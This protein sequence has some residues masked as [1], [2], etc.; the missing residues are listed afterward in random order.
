MKTGKK[1]I[2][3]LLLILFSVVSAFAQQDLTKFGV[4][5][6]SRVYTAYFRSSSGVR[7]Y[8]NKKSEFQTEIDKRTEELKK[9]Q[10]KKIDYQNDG[11]EAASLKVEA[12]I[13]KKT[14]FLMEYTRAKNV[15]LESLKRKLETSD[16][17]YNKLYSVIERVAEQ[18][19]F[20]MIMSLQ[21]ANAVLWY[22]PSIDITDQF[23]NQLSIQ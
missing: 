5:D 17:F 16:D 8:E 3:V 2:F 9:L 10:Q 18:N 13:T 7:N 12:E 1:L 21:Q 6:T 23:I 14:D 20:S 11:N 15:E 4:I 22:S 19:G